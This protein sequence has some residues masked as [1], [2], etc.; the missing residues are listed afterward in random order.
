[1]AQTG[2]LRNAEQEKHMFAGMK[3]YALQF[4]FIEPEFI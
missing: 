4:G 3:L 1:M 2:H